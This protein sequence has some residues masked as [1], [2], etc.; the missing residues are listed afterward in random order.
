METNGR[1]GSLIAISSIKAG[2][3]LFPQFSGAGRTGACMLDRMH[4]TNIDSGGACD[5]RFIIELS[6]CRDEVN[7]VLFFRRRV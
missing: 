1:L 4:L 7:V 2:M 6:G 3:S 5:G